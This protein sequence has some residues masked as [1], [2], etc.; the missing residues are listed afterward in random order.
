[1]LSVAFRFG[2]SDPG[3]FNC[4]GPVR[5]VF[6]QAS[7]ELPHASKE[8]FRNSQLVNRK[9]RPPGDLLFFTIAADKVSHV[10]IHDGHNR[11]IHASSGKGGSCASL[12]EGNWIKRLVAV[13][14]VMQVD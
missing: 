3:G 14:R 10:G 11:F 7:I 8:S 13:G 5:Y 2:G 12:A 1:M 4:S 6:S 9:E